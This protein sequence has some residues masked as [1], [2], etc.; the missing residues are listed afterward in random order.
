LTVLSELHAIV[1]QPGR[2]FLI[3]THS[4]ILLAYPGATIYEFSAEGVKKVAY[5]ETSSYQVTRDF[6][7]SPERFL[8][9]LLELD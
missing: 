7:A 4:P 3:A 9:H 8:R 5:E 6:L 1:Q 2:Q